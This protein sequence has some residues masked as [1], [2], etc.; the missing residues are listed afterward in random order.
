MRERA[1]IGF[2]QRA[3]AFTGVVS[4]LVGAGTVWGLV[5]SGGVPAGWRI[6]AIGAPTVFL[7]SAALMIWASVVIGKM[8]SLRGWEGKKK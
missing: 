1:W 2:L 7:V 5:E 3:L 6:V 4:L 8:T